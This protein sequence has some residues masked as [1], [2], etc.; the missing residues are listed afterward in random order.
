MTGKQGARWAEG[1]VLYWNGSAKLPFLARE[2]ARASVSYL[3]VIVWIFV[4]MTLSIMTIEATEKIP[5][6]TN[7][8]FFG[9]LEGADFLGHRRSPAFLSFIVSFNSFVP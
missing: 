8:M 7:N 2:S 1:P 6:D 3:R 9:L 5:T 4:A